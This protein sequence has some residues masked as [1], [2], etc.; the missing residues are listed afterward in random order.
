MKTWKKIV[1]T[2]LLLICIV[3]VG[4]LFFFI[5]E[6]KKV[7]RYSGYCMDE[8][9]KSLWWEELWNIVFLGFE[10]EN[11]EY[12]YSGSASFRWIDFNFSC[13][14]LDEDNINFEV[15]WINPENAP[16]LFATQ[17]T[18][19]KLLEL[20]AE[21]LPCEEWKSF[22][23]FA[24]LWKWVSQNWNLMYY[25][26]DEVM[27]FVPEEDWSLRSVCYRIAPVAM[28]ISSSSEWFELVNAENA[29]M[30][31]DF[32]IEDYK[33]EFDGWRLDEA[34]RAIFSDEAFAVWQERDYWE[35]FPDYND[36]D[37]KSFD[38]RAMEYFSGN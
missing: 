5:N 11:D 17:L 33:P 20:A 15:E 10:K 31:N 34:V 29:E 4:F 16:D 19:D 22:A 21:A 25:W 14:V 24:I 27:W 37:R 6:E 23:N 13:T 2:T 36:V 35:Y 3:L 12:L 1:L 28:E 38:E 8:V 32:L 7:V 30:E 18:N 26:V 9:R